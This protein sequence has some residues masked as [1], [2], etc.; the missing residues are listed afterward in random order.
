MLWGCSAPQTIS[1]Y[2]TVKLTPPS[3]LLA[4]C[5]QPAFLHNPAT[6]LDLLN[7]AISLQAAL[8]ACNQDKQALRVFYGNLGKSE[9]TQ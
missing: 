8:T 3:L 2:K 4:D 5:A 1:E 9:E 6:N 7:Y